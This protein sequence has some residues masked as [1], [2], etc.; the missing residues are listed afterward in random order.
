[1]LISNVRAHAFIVA[2]QPQPFFMG[3]AAVD[4]RRVGEHGG[5]RVLLVV[6]FAPDDAAA[7]LERLHQLPN[8]FGLVRFNPAVAVLALGD[9]SEPLSRYDAAE[10]RREQLTRL[11][12]NKRVLCVGQL[13]VVDMNVDRRER[14]AVVFPAVGGRVRQEDAPVR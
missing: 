12:L 3:R 11:T 8:E 6:V 4:V 10:V 9:A 5:H 13:D 14:A 7:T 1:M 2:N